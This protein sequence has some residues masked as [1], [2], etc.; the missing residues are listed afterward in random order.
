MIRVLS[1]FG[2]NRNKLIIRWATKQPYP[3][4]SFQ[5]EKFCMYKTSSHT[6]TISLKRCHHTVMIVQIAYNPLHVFSRISKLNFIIDLH[7]GCSSIKISQYYISRSKSAY[8]VTFIEY[9][10]SIKFSLEMTTILKVSLSIL[11]ESN[12]FV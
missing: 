7:Q 9:I 5:V 3:P 11:F 10:I 8:F 1:L 12:Q 4:L 6:Y 2:S